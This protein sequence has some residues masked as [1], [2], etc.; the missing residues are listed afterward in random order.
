MALSVRGMLLDP[1]TVNH[2][3]SKKH[4]FNRNCSSDA[5][6]RSWYKHPGKASDI[7]ITSDYVLQVFMDRYYACTVAE[8]VS[9]AASISLEAWR[10]H[11]LI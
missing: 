4:N 6:G 5:A 9:L 11:L 3:V 8:V 10:V 1:V 2:R 7:G